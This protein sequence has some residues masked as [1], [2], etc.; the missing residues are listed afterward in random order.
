MD[1]E[2]VTITDPQRLVEFT[3]END[4]LFHLT[5]NEASLL[6]KYMDTVNHDT[7]RELGEKEGQLFMKKGIV[8]E[9]E[10]SGAKIF[11]SADWEPVTMDE[12]VDEICEMNYEMRSEIQDRQEAQSVN[13][14]DRSDY[15]SL[16]KD[17]EKLEKM[18]ARTE[19]C[20]KLDE[21]AERMAKEAVDSYLRNIRKA[22]NP[23]ISEDIQRWKNEGQ[24]P[25]Q[26]NVAGED[27]R[28]QQKT[29]FSNGR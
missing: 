26:L 25:Q 29:F 8:R 10:L 19:F 22:A 6:F 1:K 9:N 5:E 13:P 28:L 16:I 27:M 4:I 11:Y 20:S 2:I 15:E 17:N 24:E 14:M 23:E 18:F 12:V 21:L 3:D 7:Y